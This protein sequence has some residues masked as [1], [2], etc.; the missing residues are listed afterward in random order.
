MENDH[1]DALTRALSTAESRRRTLRALGGTLL[2][3]V[4][5]S[6]AAFGLGEDAAAKA[7]KHG[8][9]HKDHTRSGQVQAAGKKHKKHRHKN[10]DKDKDKDKP[11][12]CGPGFRP[13]SNGSCMA[14]KPGI[15]CI[16]E[17][18]CPGGRCRPRDG[19][20][21]GDRQCYGT[22]TC[23]GPNECCPT[24]RK[25]A[26]SKCFPKIGP[27]CP[28]QKT[29]DDGS[30]VAQNE[31]CDDDP[32]PVC[33]GCGEV[34]CDNGSWR[35]RTT[36]QG[37]R[38]CCLGVCI[39]P[40]TNGCGID[41]GCGHCTEA[42]AGK[43]YCEGQDI[44]VDACP[45]GQEFDSATCRCK[46]AGVCLDGP[47]SCTDSSHH[48]CGNHPYCHCL[49]SI[50]G[51]NACT[52]TTYPYQVTCTKDADCDLIW[53]PNLGICGACTQQCYHVCSP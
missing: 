23:V 19:C 14:D 42:P 44:C 24:E 2:G 45:D 51:D 26:D 12:S 11:R 7:K 36:C 46:P 43:V 10:K 31:C 39:P 16:D 53:G 28:E 41:D 52:S 15:C 48:P 21:P 32:V 47:D 38:I 22:T 33:T 9:R 29:C 18:F 50:E 3:G 35:C 49:M 13:C 27:C 20:C 25:C 8:K 40:C 6:L 4:L 37:D 30:C 34:F 5:G 17:E 1:F